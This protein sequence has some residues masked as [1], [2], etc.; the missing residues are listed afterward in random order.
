MAFAAHFNINVSIL[1]Q[2]DT[3]GERESETITCIIPV[4][5]FNYSTSYLK[6]F[7]RKR[8]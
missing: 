7:S 8:S 5:D 6:S 1:S 4:T 2:G 3:L